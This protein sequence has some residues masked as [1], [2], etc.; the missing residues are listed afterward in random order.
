MSLQI[1]FEDIPYDLFELLEINENS[2]D[3]EIKKA[4]K[5]CIVK[6]HPD[7]NTNSSDDYF[8]WITLAYKILSDP[9]NKELY[10]E[11]KNWSDN[12]NKLKSNRQDIKLN[13][14]KT[15]KEFEQEL[16]QKHGYV[17]NYDVIS[18]KDTKTLLNKLINE[19]NQVQVI[20]E[21]IS[22]INSAVDNLKQNKNK[23]QEKQQ[24][25]IEFQGDLGTLQ[26]GSNYGALSDIGKLYGENQV[27]I[28]KNMSSM[29]Y[30]FN[31]NPYQEYVENTKTLEE[32][33]KDYEK[34]TSSLEKVHEK[35][36]KKNKTN[37]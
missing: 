16:N 21:N 7:K 31:L 36:I 8:S 35:T 14:T 5:K 29:N 9:K 25:I 18:S 4:Y 19:R 30:A 26:T 12:H 13:T 27:V 23:L 32:Q 24:D 33:I 20:N 37:I 15:Y 11:W 17:E 28:E 22:D 2:T 10:I 3:K 34:E 1:D 6:Y